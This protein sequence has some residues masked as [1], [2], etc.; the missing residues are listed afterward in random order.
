MVTGSIWPA[1]PE[2][3]LTEIMLAGGLMVKEA[4]FLLRKVCPLA[5]VPEIETRY[6]VGTETMSVDGI[7]K[8][9]C[10]TLPSMATIAVA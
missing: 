4:L 9:T 6:G 3:G 5:A 1:C 2:F 8:V 7:T 10:R